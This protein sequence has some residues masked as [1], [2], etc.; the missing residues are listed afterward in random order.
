MKITI[1]G[2]GGSTTIPRAFC[3]CSICQEA[4]IIQGPFRRTGPGI[5]VHGIDLLI[6][7]S[8]D[9]REQIER[10]SIPRI[11]RCFYSHWHP[12]HSS[13]HRI[14][15]S[16]LDYKSSPGVS[17]QTE[18]IL[19]SEVW[20]DFQTYLGL[21]D[22]FKYYCSQGIVRLSVYENWT[23]FP[24]E[25]VMVTLVPMDN[26]MNCGILLEQQSR[27]IL[28]APDEIKGWRPPA[29]LGNLDLVV[30]SIG[31]C[32]PNPLTKKWAISRDHPVLKSDLTFEEVVQ[33]VAK[34]L[35][36]SVAVLTHIE[37]PDT[38]SYS[39]FIKVENQLNIGSKTK[40]IIAYD[41]LELEV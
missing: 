31:I 37:E 36:P 18:V 17:H 3:S 34:D 24:I 4:R 10:F 13:G 7:T 27:R 6:D 29:M 14:F 1:L 28:I 8:E 19:S 32:Q 15:Q 26:G 9:I 20:S 21:A 12:D 2:S 25:D 5:F 30:L 38:L 41:G 40:F 22:A 11:R 23:K 39:D 16:N 35:K 33:F